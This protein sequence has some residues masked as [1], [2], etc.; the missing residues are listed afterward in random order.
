MNVL[1]LGLHEPPP[2]FHEAEQLVPRECVGGP[3]AEYLVERPDRQGGAELPA[4]G[5]RLK[6]RGFELL[7]C[8]L[9]RSPHR[10]GFP[11][12]DATEHIPDPRVH[13]GDLFPLA[14]EVVIPEARLIRLAETRREG[15]GVLPG[16]ELWE[17]QP[18]RSLPAM[19]IA[20][21]GPW[22]GLTLTRRT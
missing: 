16:F 5:I 13:Q 12:I 7:E 8:V 17:F 18:H 21:M 20:P 2:A 11:G 15:F 1:S 3:L 14:E 19:K 10:P 4:F 9:G 22:G 6:G